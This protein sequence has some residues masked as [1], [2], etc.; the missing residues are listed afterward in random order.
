MIFRG[1]EVRVKA[2][3][4]PPRERSQSLDTNR[5]SATL[6]LSGECQVGSVLHADSK[7]LTDLMRV[8]GPLLG[9]LLGGVRN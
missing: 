1:A 4:S 8:C 3:R 2:G 5:A 9:G 6:L 7:S